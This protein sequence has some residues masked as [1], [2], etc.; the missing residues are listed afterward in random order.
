MRSFGCAHRGCLSTQHALEAISELR[1][2]LAIGTRLADAAEARAL[3]GNTL[4]RRLR[5]LRVSLVFVGW[6]VSRTSVGLPRLLGSLRTQPNLE[7]QPLLVCNEQAAEADMS[8]L[9]VPTMAGSNQ[10]AEFSGYDEGIARLLQT[11]DPPDVWVIANDRIDSYGD[12]P[13]DYL[14][15]AAL[16]LA[17]DEQAVIGWV[18][19]LPF[20][21]EILGHKVRYYVRSNFLVV[22]ERTRARIGQLC[23]IQ[24]PFAADIVDLTFDGDRTVARFQSRFPTYGQFLVEWLTGIGDGRSVA[25]YR[26]ARFDDANW[27]VMRKKIISVLNEHLLA[28]RLED[29]G[30]RVLSSPEAALIGELLDGSRAKRRLVATVLTDAHTAWRF[31]TDPAARRR[32]ATR[33]LFQRSFATMMSRMRG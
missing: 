16:C 18:E 2:N 25:W 30:A 24:P 22:S 21:A 11:S 19:T 28:A 29:A 26:A 23:T 15:H 7:V 1:A 27:P 14:T 4:R 12:A 33:V 31:R 9:G 17:V 32:L 3:S 6:D 10:A 5:R 8:R 20:K 13:A